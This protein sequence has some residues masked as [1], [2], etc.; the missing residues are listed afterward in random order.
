MYYTDQLQGVGWS[1]K[2]V[3]ESM[4]TSKNYK[5]SVGS[6]IEGEDGYHWT[7]V[8]KSH[9]DLKGRSSFLY[10]RN[11]SWQRDNQIL[12]CNTCPVAE[13]SI[14]MILHHSTGCK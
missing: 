6:V 8:R 1:R 13:L 4:I 12:V 14:S 11:S 3:A 7:L 10:Y 2:A 5:C 9:R